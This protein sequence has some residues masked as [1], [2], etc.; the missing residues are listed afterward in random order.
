MSPLA[1]E[2]VAANVKN[3]IEDQATPAARAKNH[4]EHGPES[5]SCTGPGLCQGKAVRIVLHPNR[6]THGQGHLPLKVEAVEALGIGIAQQAS[7]R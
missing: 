7:L 2:P 4:A 6:L 3:A 5:L 1:G